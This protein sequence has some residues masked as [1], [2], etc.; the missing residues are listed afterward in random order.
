MVREVNEDGRRVRGRGVVKPGVKYHEPWT[1]L[2]HPDHHEAEQGCTRVRQPIGQQ[3][4]GGK[5]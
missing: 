3:G 1:A 5:G 2:Q 4:E